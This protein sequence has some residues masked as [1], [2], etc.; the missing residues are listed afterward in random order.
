[1]AVPQEV[2]RMQSQIMCV[3]VCAVLE[4]GATSRLEKARKMATVFG[5]NTVFDYVGTRW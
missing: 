1:M 4:D 5:N 3:H 2:P